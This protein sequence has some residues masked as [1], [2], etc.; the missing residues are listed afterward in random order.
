M[1]EGFDIFDHYADKLAKKEPEMKD[2]DQAYK[3]AII[4]M[5]IREYMNDEAALMVGAFERHG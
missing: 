3:K 2:E 4:R 1:K 5:A